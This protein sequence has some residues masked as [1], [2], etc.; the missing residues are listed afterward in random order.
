MDRR[1][2]P[3]RQIAKATSLRRHNYVNFSAVADGSLLILAMSFRQSL[4]PIV[5]CLSVDFPPLRLSASVTCVTGR[6]SE[7]MLLNTCDATAAT[8]VSL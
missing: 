3:R 6:S 5:S 2:H 4:H 8:E 7:I 1:A